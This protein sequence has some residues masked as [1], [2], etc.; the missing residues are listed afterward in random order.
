VVRSSLR[1]LLFVA[2]AT[3]LL[4]GPSVTQSAAVSDPVVA[5]AGDIACD[6]T[7]SNYNGGLGTSSNC[8]QKYT[9]DLLVGAS[10]SAVLPLGDNQNYCGS[11]AAYQQAYDPTWGRVKSISH[12]AVGNHEYLASGGGSRGTLGCDPTNEGA[13]GYFDYWGAAAGQRGQ[14]YYSYEIGAWHVI[15]LN[16][17]CSEAGGCSASSPQGAWLKA[18]L[19]AHPAACTLAYWHIPLF[20]SGGRASSNS[21]SFWDALYA[22]H[23]DVILDGHDHIYERF[24]PQSPTGAADP[25]GIRE[26]IV[27]T[28]GENHTSIAAV[29][30]NSEVRETTTYGVLELTLHP[31]SYDWNFVPEAGKTFT[32]SGSATCQN[33]STSAADTAPPVTSIVCDGGS[34]AGSFTGTVTVSLSATDPS[35]V[36]ATYYTTDGSDPT[37]GTST[38]TVYT[39]PFPVAKT[40]TIR[41]ASVDTVG[42]TESPHSQTIT[43]ATGGGG[44]GGGDTLVQ[45]ATGS[46]SSG[47]TLTLAA[48]SATRA[49]DA[50]VAAIALR[51]GSSASVTAVRDSAGG[52][53]TK[54]AVGYLTGTNSRVEL[55]YRLAT[56]A[57]TS[58]TVTLSKS[59]S[60]T[61]LLTEWAG[62]SQLDT[63]AGGSNASSTTAS[64]PTVTT[65][66][67]DLVIGAINYPN[68]A[69]SSLQTTGYTPLNDYSLSTTIHGRAAYT[70]TNQTGSTKTTWTLST[71]SGG[72]GGA[73]LALKTTGTPSPP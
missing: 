58:V 38:R 28:G 14:G 55:W 41:Y 33:A 64:T 26:F 43:I 15:V 60:A 20:S 66:S 49:G 5:A 71:A 30:A 3:A 63:A 42:N 54:G 7:N 4:L 68:S 34:C 39:G 73:I 45:Q 2:W 22:A 61:G 48:G 56:P 69:G 59:L 29:A 57:V 70:L 32:D 10:P 35:G 67:T 6:P 51:A 9:S 52:T 18:D 31:G 23:A 65:T 8:R 40:T 44:G 12:P 24:A 36:Q 25:K 21:R 11:L 72:S 53:W 27:G 46:V 19:A 62:I 16:S 37:S 17:N 47:T 50:L 13:A 1:S